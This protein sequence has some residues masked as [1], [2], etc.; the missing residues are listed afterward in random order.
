MEFQ[1]GWVSQV[2]QKPTFAIESW[3]LVCRFVPPAHLVLEILSRRC[4]LYGLRSGRDQDSAAWKVTDVSNQGL[5]LRFQTKPRLFDISSRSFW[6]PSHMKSLKS[7]ATKIKG[8]RVP[9]KVVDQFGKMT[10]KAPKAGGFLLLWAPPNWRFGTK[11]GF[12]RSIQEGPHLWRHDFEFLVY[13]DGGS[14]VAVT[15]FG[16]FWDFRSQNCYSRSSY[17]GCVF[18]AFWLVGP[19][20][21]QKT[22]LNQRPPVR[23]T[24]QEKEESCWRKTL[25]LRIPDN[26]RIGR[27]SRALPNEKQKQQLS[28]V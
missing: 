4:G 6:W 27:Y 13:F 22:W 28:G 1:S 20:A 7:K 18:L 25:D 11:W 9:Q 5:E 14:L 8:F 15:C 17:I 19:C 24:Q 2:L 12:V 10:R 26:A 23:R 3:V 16:L 21:I